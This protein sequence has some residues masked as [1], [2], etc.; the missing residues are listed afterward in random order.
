PYLQKGELVRVL[1]EWEFPSATG[2]AVFPGRRLMPAK[3]RAFLDMLEEV[4]C[5]RARQ[6]EESRAA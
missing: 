4:C 3:T 5:A 6:Q 1:P 2:W